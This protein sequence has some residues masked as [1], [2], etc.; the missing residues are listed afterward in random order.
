MW[1][2]IKAVPFAVCIPTEKQDHELRAKLK[3]ELSGIL[4]WSVAGCLEWQRSGLGTAEEVE[5]ATTAYR[6]EEDSLAGFLETEC[7][8]EPW[9][10]VTAS[11]PLRYFA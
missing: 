6:E 11:I 10:R 4:A 5:Q 1:R 7:V 3:A 9:A 8:T 2:R